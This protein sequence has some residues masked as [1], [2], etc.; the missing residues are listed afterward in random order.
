LKQKLAKEEAE[1][2][3]AAEDVARRARKKAFLGKEPLSPHV[4]L[5]LKLTNGTK[6]QRGFAANDR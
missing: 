4:S 1:R 5:M 3:K 2:A 6:V